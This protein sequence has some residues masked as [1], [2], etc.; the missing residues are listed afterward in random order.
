MVEIEKVKGKNMSSK[1]WEAEDR[2]LLAA[3]AGLAPSSASSCS[4]LVENFP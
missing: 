3:P 2:G 1:G 4:I